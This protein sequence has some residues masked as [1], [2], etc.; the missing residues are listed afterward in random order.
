MTIEYMVHW[1]FEIYM[2]GVFFGAAMVGIPIIAALLIKKK[3]R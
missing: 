3:R 1:A 2:N